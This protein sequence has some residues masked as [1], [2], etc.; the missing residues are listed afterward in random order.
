MRQESLHEPELE[1]EG[2]E[3]ATIGD[4]ILSPLFTAMFLA[5]W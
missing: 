4:G 3:P 5:A 1:V 2:I